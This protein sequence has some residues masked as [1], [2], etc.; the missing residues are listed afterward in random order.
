MKDAACRGKAPSSPDEPDPFFPERGQ[1]KLGNDAIIT[2]FR[3]PVRA[4]CDDY[5][6]R[7]GSDYGIWAGRFTKRDAEDA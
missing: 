4:E 3:C 7:T 6:K 5:R 1:A 2:C